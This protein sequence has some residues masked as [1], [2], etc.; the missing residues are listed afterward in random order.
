M[1]KIRSRLFG[2]VAVVLS[3]GACAAPPMLTVPIVT[4]APSY[5]VGPNPLVEK[6]FDHTSRPLDDK[7]SVVYLQSFGGGGTALGLL[8]PFGVAANI[9]MIKNNT[10]ADVALLKGKISLD[11]Q[12]IFAEIFREYPALINGTDKNKS[13][14]LTPLVNVVKQENEQ[15]LFGCSILVD[16]TSTG[17][18]WV[19]RYMYQIPLEYSKTDVAKGLSSDQNKML[20]DQVKK[21]FRALA[22]LY[23]DDVNGGLPSKRDIKFK[24][25]FVSPR[26]AFELVGQE[27][28][29]DGKRVEIRSVGAVYSLLKDM[30][31]ITNQYSEQKQDNQT[32][33]Q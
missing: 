27:L 17:T 3:L 22:R 14:R 24:S 20:I 9:S 21:G 26:F 13:V 29:S 32:V 28:R 31:Q 5:S 18:S 4:P 12:A 16:Y 19:G 11:P 30:T 2:I 33:R 15:L 6:S 25:K 10:D 7:N 8:G 1:K 23:L